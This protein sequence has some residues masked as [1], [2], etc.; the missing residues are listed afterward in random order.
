MRRSA[1]I[2]SSSSFRYNKYNDM[3][4]LLLNQKVEYCHIACRQAAV[5]TQ[6]RQSIVRYHTTSL[7]QLVLDDAW[8]CTSHF[9]Q[10]FLQY[11]NTPF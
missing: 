2:V 9:A 8:A 3:Y 10:I 11:P 4:L 6:L 1:A 7:L 5:I